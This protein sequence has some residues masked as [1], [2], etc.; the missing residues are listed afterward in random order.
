MTEIDLDPRGVEAAIAAVEKIDPDWSDQLVTTVATE[1]VE[2]YVT[3]ALR[4]RPMI[5]VPVGRLLV[6]YKGYD[7]LLGEVEPAEC[8]GEDP[9]YV[10][11]G[12]PDGP[13][14]L[15]DAEGWIPV[16]IPTEPRP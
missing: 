3:E 11:V 5:E 15:V 13:W 14:Y 6:K 12:D 2:A 9:T 8:E 7:L 1:A 10:D 4:L 16:P